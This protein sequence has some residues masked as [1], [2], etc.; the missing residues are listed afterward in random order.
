M[1]KIA[2]VFAVGVVCMYVRVRMKEQRIPMGFYLVKL[3]WKCTKTHCLYRSNICTPCKFLSANTIFLAISVC[4]VLNYKLSKLE[5]MRP[6]TL[7]LG[8]NYIIVFHGIVI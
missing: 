4:C 7:V 8:I 1:F 2:R 3:P 5:Y 6:H